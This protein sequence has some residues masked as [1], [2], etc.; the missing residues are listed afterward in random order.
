MTASETANSATLAALEPGPGQARLALDMNPRAITL[1][2]H[3]SGTEWE[4]VGAAVLDSP[5]FMK[6]IEWLRVEALARSKAGAP[7][8]IWLPEEQVLRRDW[9]ISETSAQDRRARAA[10]LFEAETEFNRED[11]EIAVSPPVP[12]TVE[13]TCLAI[14]AQTRREAE[15][16]AK[17]WGFVAGPVTCRTHLERFP[18]GADFR[19]AEKSTRRALRRAGTVIGFGV[20][21]AVAAGAAGLALWSI[22]Q[23]SGPAGPEPVAVSGK[24][25][26]LAVAA[27]LDAPVVI[28]SAGASPVRSG[29]AQGLAWPLMVI[30]KGQPAS[31]HDATWASSHTNRTSPKDSDLLPDLGRLSLGVAPSRAV[32]R[33]VADLKSEDGAPGSLDLAARAE[34]DSIRAEMRVAALSEPGGNGT[35][36]EPDESRVELSAEAAQPGLV[37]ASVTSLA[38]APGTSPIPKG[39]ASQTPLPEAETQPAAPDA[40]PAEAQAEDGAEPETV[41]IAVWTPESGVPKPANRPSSADQ[42][43]TE[44]TETASTSTGDIAEPDAVSEQTGEPGALAT[45]TTD[46]VDEPEPGLAAELTQAPS[47]RSRPPELAREVQRAVARVLRPRSTSG[48]G[49]STRSVRRAATEEGLP[50]DRT[51]LIGIINV[52]SG[53]E[54]LVR[55]PNG[56]FRRVGRGDVLDGWRV[57]LIG[58]DA[59]RLSRS[60]KNHTLLLVGR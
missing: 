54:A 40:S 41:T 35:V 53:R 38:F 33:P 2:T 7:V 4:Q 29:A 11:L 37:F 28:A 17:R 57:S 45:D 50:L 14:L 51:S 34:I 55:L 26:D 27:S 52:N 8:A 49:S 3:R 16:Y 59:M 36:P 43:L 15:H 19:A 13:T 23:A 1:Y 10:A 60:G 47:P 5:D 30:D 12:G 24:A 25:P 58:R 42:T 32:L 20:G 18:R 56:R 48:S 31:A 22:M 9:L 21:G 46:P 39:R 44:E 6:R